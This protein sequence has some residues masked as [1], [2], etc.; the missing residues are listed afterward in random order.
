[1]RTSLAITWI[2]IAI[3]LICAAFMDLSG[4]F[5]GDSVTMLKL[6]DLLVFIMASGILVSSFKIIRDQS[7]NPIGLKLSSWILILYGVSYILLGGFDDT[8]LLH[9]ITVMFLFVVSVT[10][11]VFMKKSKEPGKTM[12]HAN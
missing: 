3:S 10:T 4:V 9:A 1:M 6:W 11:L 2:L 7:K 12:L 8:G 5:R